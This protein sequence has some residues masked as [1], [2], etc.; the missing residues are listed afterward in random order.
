MAM[1][2][3]SVETRDEDATATVIK[4]AGDDPTSPTKVKYRH[5]WLLPGMKESGSLGVKGSAS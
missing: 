5:A 3:K 4:D 2:V 1:S